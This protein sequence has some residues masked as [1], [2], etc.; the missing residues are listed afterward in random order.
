MI[1]ALVP[2]RRA[3]ARCSA[4][5]SALILGRHRRA[6]MAVSTTVLADASR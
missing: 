3:A 5:P 2:A 6:Q 4:R 1:A